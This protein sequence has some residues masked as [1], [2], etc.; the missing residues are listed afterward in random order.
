MFLFF[1]FKPPHT[2]LATAILLIVEVMLFEKLVSAVLNPPF[3]QFCSQKM[4]PG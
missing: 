2:E 3:R 4:V 1:F